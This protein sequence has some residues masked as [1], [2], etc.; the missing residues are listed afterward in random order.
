MLALLAVFAGFFLAPPFDT[1]NPP[2]NIPSFWFVGL[3]HELRGDAQPLFASLASRALLAL[4]VIPLAGILY[5]LAWSRNVRRI[6]ESPD[7]MPAKHS[8]IVN[9]LARMWFTGLPFA[10]AILLFTAR[11]ISL[12]RQHRLMLAIYGGFAFAL[13]LAFSASLL[14]LQHEQWNKPNGPFVLAGFLLLACTVTGTRTIFAL[15][16]ALPAN[17]IFRITAV[18]RPG[19][20]F[21]AVR[22]SLMYAIALCCRS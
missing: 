13:S 14:G 16:I 6:V 4:A 15:P 17:W 1:L 11:T 20:Y 5:V 12:R 18:H 9:A 10:R 2:M 19:D 3:L 8:R 21:G 22:S 7:I